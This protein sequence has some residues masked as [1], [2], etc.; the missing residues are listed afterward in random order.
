MF[1]GTSSTNRLYHVIE[2]GNVSYRAGGE[3][4]YHA[5]KQRKNTTGAPSFS[6][7]IFHDFSKDGING[8][9][10][11]LFLLE[12]QTDNRQSCRLI[13]RKRLREEKNSETYSYTN[14][15]HDALLTNKKLS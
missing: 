15:L 11:G 5:I 13:Y 8:T 10:K 4:K 7:L 3:H 1:Y 2:G 9:M 14:A 6:T 12:L